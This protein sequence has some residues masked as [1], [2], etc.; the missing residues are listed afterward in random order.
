MTSSIAFHHAQPEDA[1][2]VRRLAQ[3]DSAASLHGEV[4]IALV[5][6]WPVAAIS[7]ADSR[8]VADPFVRTAHIAEMLRAYALGRLTDDGSARRRAIRAHRPVLVAH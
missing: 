1:L 4:V 7:L 5:D 8:V 6:G 3:L 2:T